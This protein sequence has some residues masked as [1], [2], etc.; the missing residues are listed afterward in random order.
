MTLTYVL[1]VVYGAL[2]DT[3]L[4][5]CCCVRWLQFMRPLSL[6]S[7]Y[8]TEAPLRLSL[9][10]SLDAVLSLTSTMHYLISPPGTDTWLLFNDIQVSVVES[11]QEV[12]RGQAYL[13]FYEQRTVIP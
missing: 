10:R 13:L 6:S 11:A 8:L 3:D 12:Q 4:C 9:P 7:L 2:G 1:V 5:A